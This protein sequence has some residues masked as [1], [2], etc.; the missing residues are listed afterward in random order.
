MTHTK[1]QNFTQRKHQG[2]QAPVLAYRQ[3]PKSALEK[4][5]RLPQRKTTKNVFVPRVRNTQIQS[6]FQFNSINQQ[7]LQKQPPLIRRSENAL[8][9]NRCRALLRLYL[10]LLK[11]LRSILQLVESI[12]FLTKIALKAVHA[13]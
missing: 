2:S 9:R 12:F 1:Q 10:H 13:D 11:Q 4:K 8:L 7:I 3:D 5:S 6:F